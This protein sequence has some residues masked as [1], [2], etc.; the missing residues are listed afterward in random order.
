MDWLIWTGAAVSLAGVGALVWCILFAMR[1]RREARD[2]IDL[3]ARLQHAVL[4]NFGALA[5]SVLG[6]MMVVV[7]IFMS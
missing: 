2:E 1:A 7:G 3:R 6:L 4:V 5:V